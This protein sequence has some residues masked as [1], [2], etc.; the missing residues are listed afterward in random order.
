[1]R[2]I[3]GSGILPV[4]KTIVLGAVATGNIKPK[5]AAKVAGSISK[6]GSIF[7]DCDKAAS[8]GNSNCMVATFEANSLISVTKA[9][10][11]KIIKKGGTW[12]NTVS[13]LANQVLRPLTSKPLAM[14]KPLPNSKIIS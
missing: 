8:T 10:I 7:N 1:M 3:K 9:H 12:L 2:N 6:S 5:E 11:P 14:A 13:W 4:P